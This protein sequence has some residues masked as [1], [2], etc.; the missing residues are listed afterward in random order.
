M[1]LNQPQVISVSL[2]GRGDD[3]HFD[4]HLTN[5]RVPLD[6]GNG[7]AN[8]LNQISDHELD[9]IM[10]QVDSRIKERME[11]YQKQE[12]DCVE[13]KILAALEKYFSS[14]QTRK[15]PL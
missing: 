1:E 4:D 15:L 14:T 6:R 12:T 8:K 13:A 9:V 7:N 2:K 11:A 10:E 5:C 3:N